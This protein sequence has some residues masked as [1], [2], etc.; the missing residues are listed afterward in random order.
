MMS[1]L[2]PALVLLGLFTLLT[3]LVYPAVV[4]GIAQVVFPAQANGSLVREGERT[5]GSALVGQEFAPNPVI[6]PR[7]TGAIRLLC[8]NSSRA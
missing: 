1:H 8:R 5:V 2:R 6:C 3:G 7:Q 4:T